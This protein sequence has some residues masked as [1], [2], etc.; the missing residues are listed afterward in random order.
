M[1][2]EGE[3]KGSIEYEKEYKNYVNKHI[4]L[5]CIK[6][7]KK[8]DLENIDT[9][10]VQGPIK[11]FLSN[12]GIMGRI[13][14]REKY[15]GWEE[16]LKVEISKLGK[17]LEQFRSFEIE[18]A[19]LDKWQDDIRECYKKIRE[20]VGPTSASKILHLICPSFF[21]LW[22]SKIREANRVD[23]TPNG[24]F[25]FMKKTQSFINENKEIITELSNEYRKPR[26]KIVDEY[27][28][29]TSR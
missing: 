27:F 18:N 13:L 9:L 23:T 12:W 5:Q 16:K 21:P 19:D 15:R 11:T 24:Y 26:L 22:D 7:M 8:V 4:Y 1:V 10:D 20:V 2:E 28:Y 29:R 6:D 17:K 3:I 25:L 14:S